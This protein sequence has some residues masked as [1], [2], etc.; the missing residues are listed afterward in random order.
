MRMHSIA[1][2]SIRSVISISMQAEAMS[3]KHIAK[4]KGCQLK[5]ANTIAMITWAIACQRVQGL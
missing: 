1:R 4:P 2:S 5:D 3:E